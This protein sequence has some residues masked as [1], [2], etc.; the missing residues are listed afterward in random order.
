ML[1]ASAQLIDRKY[2][3]LRLSTEADI[4]HYPCPDTIKVLFFKKVVDMDIMLPTW[5]PILGYDSITVL[6][7]DVIPKPNSK[8]VDTH[9]SPGDL[10]MYHYTHDF[11]F[12][13]RPDP[14]P[15]DR[16]TRLL[17]LQVKE[18]K[19]GDTIY[20]DTVLRKYIHVEW[21]TGLAQSNKKNICSELN[22]QGKSC[23]FYTAGHVRRDI[24][25]NWPTL[26]D[27]VHVEGLWIWDRGHPPAGTEIHPARLVAIR[28]NLP[29][30]IEV[31]DFDGNHQL[32]SV[33]ATRIDIFGS[34]DGGALMNNM[35]GVPDFVERTPMNAK[36]YKFRVRQTLPRPSPRAELKFFWKKQKG[37]DFPDKAGEFKITP[38]PEGDEVLKESFV[39][40]EIPWKGKLNTAVFARSVFVY[41][42]E[43]NAVAADYQIDSYNVK[44]ESIWFRKRKE[45]VSRS[46][47]RVFFEVGG[48]WIFFN[49]FIDVENILDQGLGKT[50][51]RLWE[52][53][54][55]FTVHVPIDRK[56]RVHAGGWEAD[57]LDRI[58]GDL[59][60]DNSPCNTKTKR[61][62]NRKLNV[63]SPLKP[64]GCIDDHIGEVHQMHSPMDL[65]DK[66]VFEVPSD[67]RKE[68]DI[69]PCNNGNQTDIFRLKYRI[70]KIHS[71]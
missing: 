26:G 20:R 59:I 31:P 42:D 63:M 11:S 3:G 1:D 62:V 9:V 34:G 2:K 51:K 56:F 55:E 40:I 12:N 8:H 25:W 48:S 18:E 15:D 52:I 30:K 61:L 37:D 19:K 29:D 17:A 22:K 49:E 5:L 41:W 50:T 27:W 16:Y 65:I 60:D 70:D 4:G 6:E 7:G 68:P 39:W 23:G 32:K 36:N 13:V 71:Q 35:Q 53:N 54:K 45:F 24:I 28:R 44:L 46:E 64:Y 67:G 10:P 38:M 58:F 57:G 21:E 33:F 47:L 14:T 69:C 43:G 66:N